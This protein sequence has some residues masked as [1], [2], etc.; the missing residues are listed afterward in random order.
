MRPFRYCVGLS[1]LAL[2]A[3]FLPLQGARA[4]AEPK[5]TE[6]RLVSDLARYCIANRADPSKV[7]LDVGANWRPIKE[8]PYEVLGPVGGPFSSYRAWSLP[9][10]DSQPPIVLVAGVEKVP[11]GQRNICAVRGVQDNDVIVE[12]GVLIGGARPFLKNETMWGAMVWD[13]D[14]RLREPTDSELGADTV[15]LAHRFGLMLVR[16]EGQVSISF[17]QVVQDP[18]PQ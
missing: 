18:P 1:A 2:L 9:Q 4:I 10:A 15:N 11:G 7:G 3:V 5:A 12:V 14:G 16:E 13:E 6:G 8:L 17:V